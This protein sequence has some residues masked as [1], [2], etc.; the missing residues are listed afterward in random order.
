MGTNNLQS[1]WLSSMFDLVGPI[2]TLAG[3]IESDKISNSKRMPG[4][5]F[6]ISLAIAGLMLAAM[7]NRVPPK[8]TV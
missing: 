4:R 2:G 5:G 3:G 7:W 8:A 1:G 6:G